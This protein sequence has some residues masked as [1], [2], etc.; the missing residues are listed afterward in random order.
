MA[1]QDSPVQARIALQDEF[2]EARQRHEPPSVLWRQYTFSSQREERFSACLGTRPASLDDEVIRHV[3]HAFDRKL[4]ATLG[5]L[6]DFRVPDE[7][8]NRSAL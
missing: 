6:V 3:N 4:E 5:K 2:S 8:V 7:H 1:V